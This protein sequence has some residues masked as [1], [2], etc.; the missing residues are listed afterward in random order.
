[1]RVYLSAVAIV[2]ACS[3]SLSA[4]APNRIKD[5]AYASD[6]LQTL[7]IYL[8]AKINDNAKLP[9]VLWVHGG[10]WY[11]GDKY[12]GANGINVLAKEL[13]DAGYVA[14]AC[15]YRLAPKHRHPAQV[16]DV[17]RAVRWLRANADQYHIDPDRIAAVGIS[18]GGHL[19]GVMAVRETRKKFDDDL[20]K[21]S[22]RVKCA[23]SIN[24]PLDFREV[25][26][27]RT[28]TLSR[29]LGDLLHRDDP[30][31]FEKTRDD[32]SPFRFVDDKS[33]PLMLIIGTK[34][35]IVPNLHS[36]RMAEELK[37]HKVATELVIVKDGEHALF[38]R[39]SPPAH[40]A[41]FRWLKEK[42]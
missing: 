24:G 32:A 38:P 40:E 4:Q 2:L 34:D 36:E 35:D 27:L 6:D 20:D 37:K 26:E 3:V 8:P 5:L 23:V 10:G 25:R 18:A 31:E 16:D 39:V 13:T 1:M 29:A 12:H 11:E 17:Q 19:A 7:D 28:K 21:Y 15:N 14:V 22:S 33:S 42:L 41:I 30:K 9:T